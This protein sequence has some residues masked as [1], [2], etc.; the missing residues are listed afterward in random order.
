MVMVEKRECCHGVEVGVASRL[1]SIFCIPVGIHLDALFK[2]TK[3]GN[4]HGGK[5][6]VILGLQCS[7]ASCFQ[8]K[9]LKTLNPT[10]GIITEGTMYDVY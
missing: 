9:A 7:T 6:Q 4:W 3:E 5:F 10:Y 8:I 1:K 2:L